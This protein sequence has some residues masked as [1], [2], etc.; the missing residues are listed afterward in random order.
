MPL[1]S[2]SRR[3]RLGSLWSACNRDLCQSLKYG[4]PRKNSDRAHPGM[5]SIA[6]PGAALR[7]T[8]SDTFFAMMANKWSLPV[9]SCLAPPDAL[10]ARLSSLDFITHALI[11]L[12][13]WSQALAFITGCRSSSHVGT[14]ISYAGRS[15]KDDIASSTTTRAISAAIA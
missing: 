6:F 12:S 8:V 15:G 4:R 3:S 9:H 10:V 5:T 7:G 1:W 2:N 11:P 14:S 13:W